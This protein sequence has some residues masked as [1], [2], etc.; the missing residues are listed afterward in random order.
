MQQTTRTPH[1]VRLNETAYEHAR[2][3]IATGKAVLD[4]RDAWS[5]HQPSAQLENDF[6]REHGWREYGRWYLGINA[7]ASVETK[8][9]YQFPYGDFEKV[10]RCGILS[11]ESRA[12]Q[13]D[14]VDIETAA[15]H[16]H[17]ML[18]EL[19]ARA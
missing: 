15:A 18:D 19:K 6:L 3:L 11:A 16:L 2:N 4:E 5:E 9:R 13:Y 1:Q 8:E 14:H 10:H 17:G 7:E 12:A